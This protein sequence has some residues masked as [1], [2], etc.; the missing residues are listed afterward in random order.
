MIRKLTSTLAAIL[1]AGATIPALAV[2]A[3]PGT[4]FTRTQPDGSQVTLALH[5]DEHFNYMTDS[6]GYLVAL[7]QDGW[8][9][10]LD[11]QG[12]ATSLVPMDFD[13]RPKAEQDELTHIRPQQTF[14]TLKTRA[15]AAN[16]G[17]RMAKAPA[18]HRAGSVPPGKWDNA[19]G[20]DLRAIPTDGQRHVLVVLVNFSNLKWSFSDNPQAE[21][22]AMLNEPGYSGNYCTGSAADFFRA[23]SNGVYQPIFDVYGPVDLNKPYSY[24]GRNTNGQDTAPWEMVADACQALDDEVDFSIYDTNGDGYVDNVYVFYA[25]Y[26]ANEGAGDDFI[27]PHAFNLRYAMTPPVLDGVTI[28]H[29]ACSNEL[30]LRTI[31]GDPKTHSGIG[32]FCHEFGH[33]L[34]LPDVYATNYTGAFT[35]GAYCVMDHGSYNNNSRTPPL[36]SIYE[37]YALEWEKPIDITNGADI[38]MQPT[39]DGGYAYR[40]TIDPSRPTEYYL[41]ENRQQH[42]WDTFIPG[43]GMMVWH[44]DYDKSIWDANIVNDN[45][46]HQYLDLVEA[47]GSADEGSQAGD[48]FPGTSGRSEFT[49]NAASPYPAFANWNGRATQL[50]ISNIGED[51]TGTVSLRFGSGS[52]TDSP[53]HVS[54]PAAVLTDMDDTSLSFKWD[55]VPNAKKYYITVLSM[56][57]DDLFGTLETE[58]VD[59][60]TFADLEDRTSV[61]LTDL[62]P[63]LSYQ[64]SL[65]ASSDNNLSAPS[66]GF[67]A[68]YDSDLAMVSP[69]LEVTPGAD[70]ADLKWYEVPGADHYEL[71]VAS[72]AEE[73]PELGATVAWDNRR[74]PSD[75]SFPGGI[76]DTRD[77]YVGQSSPSLRMNHETAITTG[78]YDQDISALDFWA[79]TNIDGGNLSL[80]IYSIEPNY[81]LSQIAE[82][83]EVP[84]S[85]EGRKIEV[86]DIPSGVR[87]LMIVL[88]CR[89]AGL[90]MN[91]DDINLYYAGNVTDTPVGSYDACAVT[92]TTFKAEG[93]QTLTPY[94]A[95]LRAVGSSG[96]SALSKV[97]R[98]T[99]ADPSGLDDVA[100][101]IPGY[102]LRGGVLTST[103]PVS[104]FAIDGTPVAID[105]TGSVQ[106]PARGIYLVTASGK[107]SKL[108][109]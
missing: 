58:F 20:H 99:T 34:G 87:Q 96:K 42:G 12:Q 86:K 60:Y 33:V 100:D 30:T 22:K 19:D 3:R 45:P 40:V 98:F 75:W 36:Y 11:N 67:Y 95:Y 102:T 79:R 18:L 28:D 88:S 77:E 105:M 23:S 108:A 74:Y 24:Y 69:R 1:V 104:V 92:G 7:Q 13:M 89:T 85:A 35:P 54:A 46:Q 9:R 51:V 76:F 4:S 106:L 61:T 66:Q 52:D 65:Y 84:C 49:G 32:T 44:V 57:A 80:R 63:G 82:I 64:V 107:T 37:K 14:E 78:I 25:G 101:S 8:Y 109:W 70:S 17:A 31:N 38:N 90:T 27:W 72:R 71:T 62:T 47:D 16:M 41:F 56:K 39:V 29:Y 91:I 21:M 68:T 5:G 83:T 73:A 93:L 6:E 43:H 48:L 81:S 94:V 10:I 59:K 26:G 2:P 15:L 53:L 97:V 103:Q 50:D 55:P